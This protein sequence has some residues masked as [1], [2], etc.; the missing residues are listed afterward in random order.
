MTD[1]IDFLQTH[2]LSPSRHVRVHC[3]SPSGSGAPACARQVRVD[4]EVPAAEISAGDARV[5]AGCR[6]AGARRSRADTSGPASEARAIA[7]RALEDV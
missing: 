1:E 5:R 4:G 7:W 6:S 3:T 2:A